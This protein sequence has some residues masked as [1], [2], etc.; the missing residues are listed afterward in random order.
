MK[1][2]IA[3]LLLIITLLF[4]FFLYRQGK[5]HED[6]LTQEPMTASL[7][8]YGGEEGMAEEGNG[9][10]A[11]EEETKEGEPGEAEGAGEGEDPAA[12]SEEAIPS[13][14]EDLEELQRTLE[15]RIAAIGGEWSVS[16]KYLPSEEGFA[17][18]NRPM[19]AASLIKLFVAGAYLEAVQEGEVQ[20]EFDASL[21]SM[22]SQSDNDAANRLINL[23]GMDR[24]NAFIQDHGFE[25]TKLNRLMLANNGL[26]NYT[27]AEDCADLLDQVYAGIFVS[28]EASERILSA[29]K[30]QRVRTKIPAGLPEEIV[31]ANKTGELSNVEND[32]AIIF[33]PGGSYIF[34]VMSER[35]SAGTAQAEIQEMS[36]I[37]YETLGSEK[38]TAETAETGE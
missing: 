7:A 4:S 38:E 18:D 27:S 15:G 19:T 31:C 17:I 11:S 26:E 5:Q 10:K 25:D 6:S 2:V 16:V 9:E 35:V 32:A 30:E 37:I 24:I 22:L 3:S 13:R 8:G 36:R 20:D 29:L 23:L 14:A 28:G 1:N 12:P 33:A 34:C 21:T